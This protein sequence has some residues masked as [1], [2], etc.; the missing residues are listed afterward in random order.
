LF[1]V[2]ILYACKID[3]VLVKSP[4]MNKN[5]PTLIISPNN[6]KV[7]CNVIYLLHGYGGN[8]KS[9][10]TI[11]PKLKDVSDKY[12][13]I[14]VCPNGQNNWYVDSPI[15]SNSKYETFIWQELVN[16][17]DKN[18]KTIA[19]KNSR[20][21]TGFSMGGY[22][23][24]WISLKHPDIFGAS[25]STSGALDIIALTKYSVD[26]DASP[27][28][29]FNISSVLGNKK[30]LWEKYFLYNFINNIETYK[31]AIIIDCGYD[32]SLVFNANK[33]FHQR[34]LKENIPHDYIV[35]PG[36]HDVAYWDN[37]ISYHI[38]F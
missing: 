33:K 1:T 15:D 17:V 27:N 10:I 28:K 7:K 26:L 4:S 9:W 5:I 37:A 34:L 22:G 12:N 29:D 3:N 14:F 31:M 30:A 32:D 18:Y 21:I 24:L 6:T 2:S 13:I 36:H 35:R 38:L 20:A 23:A 19:T 16:Y 8:E 11:H 25:G